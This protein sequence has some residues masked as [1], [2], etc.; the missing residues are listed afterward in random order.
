MNIVLI[1]ATGGIGRC[2]TKDLLNNH[3]LYLGG[4]NK[5]N[6][7]SLA[8]EFN[9]SSNQVSEVDVKSFDSINNFMLSDSAP[10]SSIV[11]LNAPSSTVS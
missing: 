3:E 5:S 10:A 2:L 6:L 9:L 4:H 1:G 11:S 8:S 7:S